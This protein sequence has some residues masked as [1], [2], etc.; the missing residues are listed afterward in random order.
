MSCTF[1]HLPFRFLICSSW[2][3]TSQK[4][5]W[6]PAHYF[7]PIQMSPPSGSLLQ[8]VSKLISLC[9]VSH[10]VF[11]EN[12]CMNF[13]YA[14]YYTWFIHSFIH[15]IYVFWVRTM[16]P[17]VFKDLDIKEWITTTT[18]HMLYAF[19]KLIIYWKERCRIQNKYVIQ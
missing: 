9:T 7:N 13:Q 4:P 12:I 15:S 19:I 10:S 14:P 8:D 11:L 1:S 2:K 17:A 6:N 5:K 16:Q 18:K 3:N